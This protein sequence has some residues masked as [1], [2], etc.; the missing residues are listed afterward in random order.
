MERSTLAGACA[1]QLARHLVGQRDALIVKAINFAL[2]RDDW[3]HEEIKASGICEYHKY[4]NGNEVFSINGVDMIEFYPA[5]VTQ[6]GVGL[7]SKLVATRN[8]RWLV[9]GVE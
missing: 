5:Q 9:E 3:T 2:K 6:Q 1:Q 7:S 8:Y 4:S